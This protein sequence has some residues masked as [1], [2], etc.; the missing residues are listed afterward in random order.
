MVEPLSSI[1]RCLDKKG[2]RQGPGSENLREPLVKATISQRQ[3]W[4]QNHGKITYK[5]CKFMCLPPACFETGFG[6]VSGFE[7]GC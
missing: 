4:Y 1:F 7:E 5:K 6:F 2:Y 3:Y